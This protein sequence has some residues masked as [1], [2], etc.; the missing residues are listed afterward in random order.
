M[1]VLGGTQRTAVVRVK[2]GRKTRRKSLNCS[3]AFPSAPGGAGGSL[4][5]TTG[6]GDCTDA[7]YKAISV[8]EDKYFGTQHSG[9]VDPGGKMLGKMEELVKAPATSA[10]AP[11]AAA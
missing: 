10:A 5:L 7:L 3:T 9:Y 1:D 11:K 2:T 4:P 6:K 8:F